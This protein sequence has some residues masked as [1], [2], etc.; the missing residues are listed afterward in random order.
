M[1]CT[2]T[3]C[4]TSRP[5]RCAAHGDVTW[6]VQPAARSTDS[7]TASTLRTGGPSRLTQREPDRPSGSDHHLLP[8]GRTSRAVTVTSRCESAEGKSRGP[9]RL[10]WN[11]PMLVEVTRRETHPDR[12][13]A[14]PASGRRRV[15]RTR[16][17]RCPLVSANRP[18]SRRDTPRRHANP[19]R[20][21]TRQTHPHQRKRSPRDQPDE[22]RPEPRRD[23]APRRGPSRRPP[24]VS[25]DVRRTRG[26][27]G[28]SRHVGFWG[29]EVGR[30][31]AISRLHDTGRPECQIVVRPRTP[32][33]AHWKQT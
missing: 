8:A 6:M 29:Q 17:H 18:A 14:S 11:V 22:T 7:S 31:W 5:V 16:R 20:E 24:Q 13:D 27:C 9:G 32:R 10:R 12:R 21:P 1:P 30:F 23:A 28:R 33:A 26:I 2:G 3:S 15:P 4:S 19:T 25:V